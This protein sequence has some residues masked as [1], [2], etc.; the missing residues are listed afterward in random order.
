MLWTQGHNCFYNMELVIQFLD[1]YCKDE[2]V[3]IL[4][5]FISLQINRVE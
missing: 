4:I 2:S 3:H 5:V 1:A